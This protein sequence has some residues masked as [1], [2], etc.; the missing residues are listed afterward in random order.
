MK[1]RKR[2]KTNILPKLFKIIIEHNGCFVCMCRRS[3]DPWEKIETGVFGVIRNGDKMSK[4]VARKYLKN[5][6]SWTDLRK[7]KLTF[8]TKTFVTIE[9]W[10]S[11]V[12]KYFRNISNFEPVQTFN[13]FNL[14]F[15]CLLHNESQIIVSS[16]TFTILSSLFLH[17]FLSRTFHKCFLFCILFLISSTIN[18]TPNN[19]GNP[20]RIHKR[21]F[22]ISTVGGWSIVQQ[23]H[24][25]FY[26][27]TF[28]MDP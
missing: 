9:F 17:M 16:S 1:W 2:G 27:F 13:R 4:H 15:C 25:D 6:E 12:L 26:F 10:N 11:F 18:F 5:S 19:F 20:R 3:S 22:Y 24:T 23:F 28:A 7:F 21:D 14:L 8:E